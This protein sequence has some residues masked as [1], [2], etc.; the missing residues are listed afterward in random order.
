MV[1]FLFM[2][3]MLIAPALYVS[4]ASAIQ[5]QTASKEEPPII[6]EAGPIDAP[7]L[8]KA[9][10]VSPAMK[11]LQGT[12]ISVQA[13]VDAAGENVRGD[14]G[15]EPSIAVDPTAPN[16]IAVGWRQF[17]N[18]SSNFRQAGYSFSVDGGRTWA[19]KQIIEPGIF[20]S[21]PVLE[22]GPDGT[23]YY[24]SLS[25]DPWPNG[26]FLNDMFISINGGATWPTKAFAFGGDKAWFALDT[27]GG[28]GT[29]HMYQAWNT[30]GNTFFPAQFNRSVNNG[31]TWTAPV[32][33]EPASPTPARPVFGILDV[34]PSGN[35]YVAGSNNS[36]NAGTFW[37]VK[38][39]SAQNALLTP[40]FEQVT[41]LNMGGNLLIGT[42]PNPQGLLGQVN[43]AV[44]KSTGPTGGN[45]YVLCSVDPQGDDDPM[46][47]MFIRSTDGG[48]SF[49]A[50]L[51]INDDALN[52]NAWQWFGTM[53]VAPGGRIDVIWNDTRT[54]GLANV[55]ELYYSFSV[56]GGVNFSTNVALSASFNS[57]VGWPS[58][59]KLGDYY[60]MI[61][62]DVG[63]HLIYAATFNGEQDVYYLRI[64]DYDCNANGI[65]DAAD[66]AAQTEADCDANGI[67][68][69][70]QI[71]SGASLDVNAN[72]VP[73]AC[74]IP[75]DIDGDGSVNVADMLAMFADWGPCDDTLPLPPCPA[76]LNGDGVVSVIDLLLMLSNWG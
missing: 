4:S 29:D 26:P 32:E 8:E 25:I 37:L 23:F 54:S 69:S 6:L 76:D 10:V 48:A 19:G 28:I 43:V 5:D 20:R 9:K 46:D 7:S 39:G 63:A 11:V 75:G 47:V 62:D 52:T 24:L 45:V 59:N 49:S 1:R 74:D 56:D 27:T 12:Y 31:F 73:D 58:Q 14:A 17:D 50:P 66:L 3:M 57:H 60:D 21:D 64:G 18:V 2:L 72:G 67:P 42:G 44:D 71:A 33:Y 15:N 30:G 70:C 53:S 34:G 35:V 65:G 68:D 40:L 51:R 38:S 61:S 16:R 22:A 13:N 41:S 55:S 36:A